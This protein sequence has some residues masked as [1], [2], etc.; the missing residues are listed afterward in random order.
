VERVMKAQGAHAVYV[1]NFELATEWLTQNLMPND[2]L[3]TRGAG[4]IFKAG[5][6]ILRT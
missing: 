5:E 3:I 1:Q 6:R 4:D 2:L